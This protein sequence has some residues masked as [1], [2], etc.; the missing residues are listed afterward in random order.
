[1]VIGHTNQSHVNMSRFVQLVLVLIGFVYFLGLS[2]EPK[3]LLF[4]HKREAWI[5][6]DWYSFHG[7]RILEVWKHPIGK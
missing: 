2:V 7:V 6:H 4:T 1:M 5:V 3:E